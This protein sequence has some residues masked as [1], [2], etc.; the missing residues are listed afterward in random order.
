VLLVISPSFTVPTEWSDGPA[1]WQRTFENFRKGSA[2]Y[3]I[4][5]RLQITCDLPGRPE[6]RNFSQN[7]K[8]SSSE[9]ELSENIFSRVLFFF[10]G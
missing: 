1:A 5:L 3:C 9:N 2:C 7:C 8:G 6:C 4:D 10:C